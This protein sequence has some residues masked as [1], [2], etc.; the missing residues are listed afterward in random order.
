MVDTNIRNKLVNEVRR[1]VDDGFTEIDI[2]IVD[3][4]FIINPTKIHSQSD[5]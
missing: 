2:K 5:Y 4:G 3:E 1:L